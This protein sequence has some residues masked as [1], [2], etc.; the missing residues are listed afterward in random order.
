M[1]FWLDAQLSP[2]VEARE[3]RAVSKSEAIIPSCKR[4]NAA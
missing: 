1:K 3:G 4:E 2:M